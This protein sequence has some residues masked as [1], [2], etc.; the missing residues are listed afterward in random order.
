MAKKPKSALKRMVETA[1]KY[2]DAVRV[3]SLMHRAIDEDRNVQAGKVYEL[4]QSFREQIRELDPYVDALIAQNH[5][6]RTLVAGLGPVLTAAAAADPELAE[7]V[8]ALEALLGEEGF[9]A[10]GQEETPDTP[11][12]TR[13]PDPPAQIQ[14][15]L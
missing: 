12:P 4:A 9:D 2:E 10:E 11:A 14:L 1:T 13:L 5:A 7:Q 8:R 15:D 6:F 3:H